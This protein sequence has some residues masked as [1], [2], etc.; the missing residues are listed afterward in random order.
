MERML[1]YSY[2]HKLVCA[3]VRV[4]MSRCR[5]NLYKKRGPRI[6]TLR[7]DMIHY[8]EILKNIKFK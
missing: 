4:I 1:M 7:F 6:K 8:L 2:V 3:R 5:R